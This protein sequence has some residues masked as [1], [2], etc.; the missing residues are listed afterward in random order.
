MND[1][2]AGLAL[3]GRMSWRDWRSG[4]LRLLLLALVVAVASV[5]SVGFFVDRIRNGLERDAALMLGAD[6]VL[7]SDQPVAA[8]QRDAALQRGL[9]IS[10]SGQF[11]SMALAAG[12]AQLGAVKAVGAGY[13]L[14]GRL[15]VADGPNA[16]ETVATDVPAPGTVWVDP[17]LLANLGVAVGDAIRL[18]EASLRIAKLI[19]VEPDR[20][21]SFVN[22]SPRILMRADDLPATGLVQDASRVSYRLY[23]AGDPARMKDYQAWLTRNLTRGQRIETLEEGRPQVRDTVDRAERFLALVGL[24]SAMLAAVAVALAARRFSAGH[25][26]ACA[27]LRCLGLPQRGMLGMFLGEFVI[28]GVVGALLSCLLGLAGHLV[29]VRM[30]ASLVVSELP[31]PSWVPAVQGF[32][33]GFV[34]LLGFALPPVLQLRKVTPLRVLRRDVGLPRPGTAL[35]YGAAL[36]AFGA[37]LLWSARDALVGWLTAGGFL[38]AFGLFALLA[39]L[40]LRGLAA[41]RAGLAG[42]AGGAS[43]AALRFAL[44][45]MQ[46]RPAATIVQCVALAL[47]LMALLLLSVTRTDLVDAWR[48]AA[49]ADAPNRFVINIQPDQRPAFEDFT[50]AAGLGRHDLEPMIRGRL[51]AIN[52]RAIGPTDYPDERARRLVDREFNLSYMDRLPAHNRVSAGRWLTGPGEISIEEGIARTLGVKLGDRL[53]FDIA[54]TRVEGRVTSLRALQWDSMRVNF[55]VIFSPASL[56]GM[57]Q[58]WI[59]ALH[60]PPGRTDLANRMVQAFPNLTVFDMATLIR[61]IQEIL[62]QVIAAVEFLFLFTLAAGLMVLWAALLATRDERMRESALLRAMGATRQQL[63]RAQAVEFGL[64]GLLAGVMAAAG[65]VAVGWALATYAFQFPYRFTVWPWLWGIG[66]GMA[67]AL[68]GG[69]VGLRP[70]LRQPPLTSL[71]E[72]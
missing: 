32:L 7:V 26:D 33:T 72:A 4:A 13:P 17:S 23:V 15:R 35:G 37:L 14:R 21:I 39:W 55:F 52:E 36:L 53:A 30:L 69:W 71:R 50:R 38:G 51:I 67:V 34:L 70:V 54:G 46:R 6:L 49:P 22:L 27:V 5:T 20:G 1:F 28:V 8:A 2:L 64:L 40:A 16:P 56:A 60:V 68:F 66:G 63:Q 42:G 62:D 44:A 48:K 41:W 9:A 12:R 25:L 61:Q 24:A 45:A 47:G 57:P 10:T 3:A 11:P 29:L 31:A 19:V 18:G 59:A 58:T 43:G 65:A